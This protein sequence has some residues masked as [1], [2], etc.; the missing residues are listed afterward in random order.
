VLTMVVN[1]FAPAA[2]TG[3]VGGGNALWGANFTEFEWFPNPERDVSGYRVYR[4]V[5][6]APATSDELACETSV[7][8]ETPTSCMW[9]SAPGGDQRYYVVAIAPARIG[10]GVE[11]SARPAAAGT[12]LVTANQRPDAPTNVREDLSVDDG[13][14]ITIKWNT[15]NDPDG[16]IRYYRIYRDDS[17]EPVDRVARTGSGSQDSWTDRD[18]A[19]GMHRYWVTAVDEQLAESEIAPPDGFLP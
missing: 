17:S 11:E 8:D 2:P 19:T 13:G 4:M 1:R 12:L 16:T 7:D 14:A 3:F 18:G 5:G 9:P 10:T 15:S 6:S